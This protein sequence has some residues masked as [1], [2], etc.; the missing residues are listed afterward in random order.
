MREDEMIFIAV[1]INFQ[2]FWDVAMRALI[3]TD[4]SEATTTCLTLKAGALR[5]FKISVPIYR[6]T[7]HKIL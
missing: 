3:V 6:S 4:D 5:S 7:L 2:F 1:L